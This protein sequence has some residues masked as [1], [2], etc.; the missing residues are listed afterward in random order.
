MPNSSKHS[1]PLIAGP[2]AQRPSRAAAYPVLE[3]AQA[4]LRLDLDRQLNVQVVSRLDAEAV[5]V[6]STSVAAVA[7]VVSLIVARDTRRREQQAARLA[8]QPALVFDWDGSTKTWRLRNIGNGP[9]LDVVIAQRIG[10]VWTNPLR[11]PEMPVDGSEVV[12]RRWVEKTEDPGLGARSRAPPGSRCGRGARPRVAARRRARPPGRPG[13]RRRAR[14]GA[15][16]RLGRG[17][18]PPPDAAVDDHGR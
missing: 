8:R 15:A 10:S 2:E 3:I 9:A 4:A 17:D 6:V 12:P 7:L 5:D 13:R 11:M 14:G 1:G 16:R 18:R